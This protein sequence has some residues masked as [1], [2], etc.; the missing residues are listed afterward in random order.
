MG[1]RYVA[2][3]TI[4]LAETITEENYQNLFVSSVDGHGMTVYSEE[5]TNN[6]ELKTALAQAFL[7][8]AGISINY[9]V[10][11]IRIKKEGLLL[12]KLTEVQIDIQ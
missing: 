8:E 7:A 2:S 12:V 1:A 4:S 9:T 3:S 11:N 6:I 10:E 5:D